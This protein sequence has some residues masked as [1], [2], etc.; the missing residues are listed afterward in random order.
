MA[1]RFGSQDHPSGGLRFGSQEYAALAGTSVGDLAAV[2]SG[3]DVFAAD[4]YP[5]INGTLAAS[6]EA[7]PDAFASTGHSSLTD[8]MQAIES[9]EPD[10]F[11]AAGKVIEA[12][13]RFGSQ[14]HPAGGLRFGAQA[15]GALGPSGPLEAS[16][17]GSD[18]VAAVGWLEGSDYSFAAFDVLASF[19]NYGSE[20]LGAA[21][22]GTLDTG[23]KVMLPVAGPG[24]IAFEWETNAFGNPSLRLANLT[25]ATVLAEVPW[26]VWDGTAWTAATFD[27][28]DAMQGAVFMVET[29]ADKFIGNGANTAYGDAALAETETD[30]FA[31]VGSV[32][33]AGA[34]AATEEGADTF[35]ASG[36]PGYAGDAVLFEEDADTL[37]V[38]GAVVVAGDLAAAE[39]A[40]AD[41]FASTGQRA[42]GGDLTASEAGADTFAAAGRL[43]STG[44]LAA[45]EADTPDVAAAAGAVLVRG[46]AALIEAG[47]DAAAIAGQLERRGAAALVEAG[48]DTLAAAGAVAVSGALNVIDAADRFA[49]TGTRESAGEVIAAELAAA[50]GGADRF[51]ARGFNGDPDPLIT[52]DGPVRTESTT[53]KVRVQSRRNAEAA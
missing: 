16:E 8:T 48:A 23:Y 31:V 19:V 50:E 30:F 12:S 14:D 21:I 33:V 43:S 25:G 2:E 22:D 18:A 26:Y 4:S 15:W 6:E 27:V 42:V 28:S 32:R 52:F 47:A 40:A 11:V 35:E 17:S 41:T 37:A 5:R 45:V 3:A 7:A 39:A 49:S 29:G 10:T 46:A 36:A 34:A 44:T 38:A 53:R 9:P 13:L 20:S 24:G 51:V 1:E